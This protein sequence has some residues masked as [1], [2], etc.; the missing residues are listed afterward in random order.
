MRLESLKKSLINSDIDAYL[1]TDTR[2]VYYFTGFRDISEAA[3]CLVITP[4]DE[5]TLL[6]SQL[7]LSAAKTNANNCSVEGVN[8]GEKIINKLINLIKNLGAKTIHFDTLSSQIYLE[9]VKKID[10]IF[11]PNSEIIM[12]LRVHQSRNA[13]QEEAAY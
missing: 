1:V 11:Y 9:I 6:V 2:N 7:S 8:F 12:A 3:L 10:A 5:P 4:D 13:R